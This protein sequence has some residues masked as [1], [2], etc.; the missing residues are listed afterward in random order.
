MTSMKLIK[1]GAEANIYLDGKDNT[2]IKDRIKK[3]YRI[4]ELDN[5]L[6]K[7]RTRSESKLID[8]AHKLGIL[9]PKIISTE[10]NKIR[11][12]HIP[13]KI[14]KDTLNKNNIQTA[15]AKIGKIIATLHANNIIHGDLT[16]SNF[17]QK[18]RDIYLIDFGLGSISTS[19]E[20]KAVDL[21]LFEE[22][23]ESTHAGLCESAI[24]SMQTA[25]KENYN[26]SNLILK[27]LEEIRKRGRY[28]KR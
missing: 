5:R 10:Q 18:K 24:N 6:R 4:T 2:I 19:V 21:H 27:R 7:S 3:T 17:I 13:G 12:T 11:M 14:L 1:Q 28:I 15:M 8:K 26:D 23:M 20:K 25:Y 9:T 16:T 22:A